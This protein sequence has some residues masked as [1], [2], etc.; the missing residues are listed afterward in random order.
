MPAMPMSHNSGSIIHH[1]HKIAS[2]HNTQL[3]D[4]LG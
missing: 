2:M 4:V 1:F 3:S